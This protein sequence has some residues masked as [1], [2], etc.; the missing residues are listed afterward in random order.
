MV[1]IIEPFGFSTVLV[2]GVPNYL[3]FIH[4]MIII[5]IVQLKVGNNRN[6]CCGCSHIII[7]MQLEVAH[8]CT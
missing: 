4:D 3:S 7:S 1:Y 5:F 2:T 8:Q 6:G